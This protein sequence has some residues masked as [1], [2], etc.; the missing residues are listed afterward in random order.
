MPLTNILGMQFHI[1]IVD[2]RIT[3]MRQA[4]QFDN[5]SVINGTS[6]RVEMGNKKEI[7]AHKKPSG[8][9]EE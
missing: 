2:G 7:V 1:R 6:R 3:E 5:G 4:S 8:D 9:L